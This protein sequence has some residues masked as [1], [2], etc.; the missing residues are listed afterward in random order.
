MTNKAKVHGLV[1]DWV[2]PDWPLLTLPE[3]DKF[4]RR[5][6]DAGRAMRILFSS[7]RPFS[8]ASVVETPR[9]SVFVK[10]HHQ[11]VR[12]REGL[13][14]E[15]R[16]MQYLRG[17]GGR[18]P[19]VLA[20]ENGETAIHA[21]FWTYEL[22]SLAEGL[23]IYE[24]ALSWTPFYSTQQA[25]SAGRAMAQLHQAAKGYDA[26]LRKAR[27]LV[28]SFSI[29]AAQEPWP[30]LEKYVAERPVLADYLAKRPWREQ[31]QTT[32]MPYHDGLRRWVGALRPLWTH[33]DL[34]ASNFLWS[35][36]AADAEAVSVIDFGLSD[37]TNAVQDIATAIERNAIEWLALQGD[38][39]H[40]V[41]LEQ[42]D[43]ILEGYEQVS[44]L[45]DAE[46]HAIPAML[47]LV[48][49]EFALSEADY[50]LSI[51]KSEEKASVAWDGYF[52]GHAA[53][54]RTDAGKRLLDQLTTWADSRG[55][56]AASTA[57]RSGNN[58]TA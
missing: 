39:E 34:H 42:I 17:H 5:F 35:K 21:G 32:L 20:D 4:L 27:N 19:K 12:D 56:V 44:P 45:T 47:P 55:R 48:H 3:V 50:F 38:F 8:A 24:Q 15:H 46:A 30:V 37:R 58:V 14:E 22:H 43:A 31:T 29:F 13:L 23:D 28:Q 9:G 26:P 25:R 49:A 40:V 54:F 51:L 16:L 36:D 57:E 53:W 10:R 52:L 1:G 33:N 6:P 7:P 18:V 11:S 41:H 2:E